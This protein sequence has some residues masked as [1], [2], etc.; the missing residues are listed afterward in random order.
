Y[1]LI[2]K[3][4]QLNALWLNVVGL[5]LNVGLNLALVPHY[6]IVAAAVLTVFSELVILAGS[7]YL[8][9]HDFEVFPRPALLSPALLAAAA[10]P[11]LE[12]ARAMWRHCD[13]PLA[14][15]PPSEAPLPLLEAGLADFD[16]LL[17]AFRGHDVVVAQQL[18]AQLLR[19]LRRLPTRYVADLYNPLMIEVLEA[20]DG[21][22]GDRRSARRAALGVLAQCAAAGFV[23]CASETQRH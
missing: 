3:E 8:M 9:Q 1:A 16:L 2:A 19:H 4:R 11:A 14:A 13:V 20:L 10:I 21:S 18:P 23:I 15:P 17:D 5:T 7:Y 22:P 12:L 6:G